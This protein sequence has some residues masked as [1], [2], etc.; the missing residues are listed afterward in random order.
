M[1]M[2]KVSLALIT[3]YMFFQIQ[4]KGVLIE[5]HFIIVL[6]SP[7]YISLFLGHAYFGFLHLINLHYEE[8][9]IKPWKAY[10][11]RHGEHFV[12]VSTTK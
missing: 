4:I 3:S 8:T 6:D 11:L 1:N 7:L 2:L 9:M 12:R 5:D 10:A